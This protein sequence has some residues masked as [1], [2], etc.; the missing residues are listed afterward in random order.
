MQL[1]FTIIWLVL[2]PIGKNEKSIENYIKSIEL[3]KN[4]KQ[5]LNGLLNVLSQTD[6]I[7]Y[8]IQI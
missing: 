8:K 1:N 4:F 2:I 7:K 6:E 5:P 3:N